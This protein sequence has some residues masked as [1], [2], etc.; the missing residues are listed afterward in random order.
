MLVPLATLT[1]ILAIAAYIG[2]RVKRANRA[3]DDQPGKPP[4]SR[5][6]AAL[7]ARICALRPVR[8]T[9][10]M[11]DPTLPAGALTDTCVGG[12]RVLGRGESWPVNDDG[13]PLEALM[14]VNVAQ[15]ADPPA[16]LQGV[17]F[18]AIFWDPAAIA[19]EYCP[20]GHVREY[21]SLADLVPVTNAPP[22]EL[23]PFPVR[24]MPMRDRANHEATLEV[25]TDYTEWTSEELDFLNEA[26]EEVEEAKG[27]ISWQCK[28]GGW[29]ASIQ[30]DID[31]PLTL[32]VG[33]DKIARINLADTGCL[34]LWRVRKG[35]GWEW[36]SD[37]QFY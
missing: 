6:Y 29:P 1:L 33:Y 5:D 18:V 10:L 23:R 27:D 4:A 12:V 30:D 8:T 3:P 32:Q 9:I 34:Y 7:A 2:W 31:R 16:E 22:T 25:V 21:T 17:A 19:D 24:L 28:V 11:P 35:A 14:Q 15:I 36:E 20:I 13:E 26:M 37:L